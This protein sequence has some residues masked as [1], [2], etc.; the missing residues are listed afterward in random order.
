[1]ERRLM[2]SALKP[3]TAR[4]KRIADSTARLFKTGRTPG[5]AISTAHAWVLGGA[6]NAVDAPEN[7]FERVLNCACVSRPM[8]ISHFI[9]G[10][11]IY[12]GGSLG[13]PVGNVRGL[14]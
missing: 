3:F 13:M 14:V 4:P 9:G 12:P 5:N 1:R 6:P 2:F 10:L 11:N 8:T 7:I